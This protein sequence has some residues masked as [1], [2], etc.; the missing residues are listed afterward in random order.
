MIENILM[1]ESDYNSDDIETIFGYELIHM[2]YA[3]DLPNLLV[4]VGVY[5]TTSEA[6]RAGR[7]GEI[8]K[9]Y[10]ELKASKTR[11]LYIWNP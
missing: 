7:T 11:R 5:K 1:A 3:S 2:S 6:R 10:T 8:P 4:E 9:G